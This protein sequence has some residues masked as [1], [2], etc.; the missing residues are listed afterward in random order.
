MKI[1]PRA[2]RLPKF[3]NAIKVKEKIGAVAILPTIVNNPFGKLKWQ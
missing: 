3:G 2:L 1:V